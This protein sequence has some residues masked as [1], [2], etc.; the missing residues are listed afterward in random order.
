[1]TFSGVLGI[2]LA[3]VSTNI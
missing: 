1:M 2:V 3:T